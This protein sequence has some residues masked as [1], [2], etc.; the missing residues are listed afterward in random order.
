MANEQVY[1]LNVET[2]DIAKRLSEIR[3]E[4]EGNTAKIQEYQKSVKAGNRLT[5]EQNNELLRLRDSNRTLKREQTVLTQVQ[6]ANTNSLDQQRKQ[7]IAARIQWDKMSEAERENSK[8]GQELKKTINDLNKAVSG[9]EESTGRFQ[10]GVGNYTGAIKGALVGTGAFKG[11]IDA[12]GLAIKGNPL[13]LLTN[14]VQGIIGAFLKAQPVVDAFAVAMSAISAVTEVLTQRAGALFTSFKFLIGGDFAGAAQS[15]S[16][17]FGGLGA[18][19]AEAA[20]EGAKYAEIMKEVDDAL[21]ILEIR[22]SELAIGTA[23]LNKQFRDRTR[24]D[25]ERLE[26]AKSIQSIEEANFRERSKWLEVENKASRERLNRLLT[27]AGVQNA[28]L[29]SD[30]KALEIAQKHAIVDESWNKVKETRIA[31]NNREAESESIIQAAQARSNLIAEQAAEKAQKAAENAQRAREKAEA[32]K[33]KQRLKDEQTAAQLIKDEEARQKAFADLSKKELDTQLKATGEFYKDQELLRKEQLA[34]DLVAVA[35]NAEAEKAV[36]A[37]AEKDIQA[38]K[39]ESTQVQIQILEDYADKV[40]GTD[41]MIFERQRQLANLATE[42]Q[43]ALYEKEFAAKMEIIKKDEEAQKRL[44]QLRQQSFI[45]ATQAIGQQLEKS[46]AEYKGDFGG[47]VTTVA[48]G[49]L[50]VTLDTIQ[51]QLI[52]AQVASIAQVSGQ[53]IV[54]PALL[55]VA[56]LRIAAITAAFGVAKKGINALFEPAIPKFEQGGA[57]IGRR[58]SAGGVPIEVEGGEF[59]MNRNAYDLFPRQIEAMNAIGKG[60]VPDAPIMGFGA[61]S[62]LPILEAIENMRPQVDV[63]EIRGVMNEVEAREFKRRS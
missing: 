51:K 52:A 15:A 28:N 7:L 63:R 49:V 21:A 24:T 59:V 37:Q 60:S 3:T 1:S 13:M 11:G 22:E 35:G 41:D 46:I 36:R 56:G 19:I 54:N 57:V 14:V 40:A 32:D 48:K 50:E 31:L 55:L 47:F 58:H 8:E 16:E 23:A 10:R 27:Q 61:D 18:S 45:Q 9:A 20:R 62:L 43:I 34:R 53:S 12:V 33:E 29:L 2:G 30:A 17:A 44:D 25:E 42:E 6:N 4:L 26:I 5:D 39:V 38:L